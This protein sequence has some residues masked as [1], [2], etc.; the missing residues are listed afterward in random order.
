VGKPAASPVV[1]SLSSR[2]SG[3][4][5]LIGFEPFNHWCL[6]FFLGKVKLRKP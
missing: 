1:T 4:K 6:Y 2:F 5:S 3:F